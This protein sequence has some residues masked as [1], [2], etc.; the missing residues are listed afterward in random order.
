LCF[1]LKLHCNRS[2]KETACNFSD[3]IRYKDINQIKKK[4]WQEEI[5]EQ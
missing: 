2:V 5:T 1:Y 3:S 4:S